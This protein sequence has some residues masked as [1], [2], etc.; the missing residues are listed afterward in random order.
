MRDLKSSMS[1]SMFKEVGGGGDT[2]IADA[3][4]VDQ[5]EMAQIGLEIDG[6]AVQGDAMALS[7]A[8]GGDLAAI[9]PDADVVG[10]E[11]SAMPSSREGGD[12]RVFERAHVT[13]HGQATRAQLDDG[14]ADQLSRAV[15]RDQTAT[16]GAVDFDT[17]VGE[18][19]SDK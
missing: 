17:P 18:R 11:T 9:G 12:Y 8:D 19:S 15:V 1:T 7:D 4:R 6:E 14:I 2:Q 3:A 16:G 10:I 13:R 5:G